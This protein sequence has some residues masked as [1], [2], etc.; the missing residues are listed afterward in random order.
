M[1]RVDQIPDTVI[2]AAKVTY[3]AEIY[4]GQATARE[5]HDAMCAAI[6]SALNAWPEAKPAWFLP[7]GKVYILPAPW[8]NRKSEVVN[9]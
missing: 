8:E 7:Q 6:T 3:T 4:K 5:Y 9:D 1:I 2:E